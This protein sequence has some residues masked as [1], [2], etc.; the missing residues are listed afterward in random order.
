MSKKHHA[1]D[2]ESYE[3]NLYEKYRTTINHNFNQNFRCQKL[4]QVQVASGE[5]EERQ[6]IYVDLTGIITHVSDDLKKHK[7]THPELMNL[8]LNQKGLEKA[9]KPV[10]TLDPFG[11]NLIVV[12]CNKG[13][14][15]S[16]AV[17]EMVHE[18]LVRV[19]YER[20]EVAVAHLQQLDGWTG[21]HMCSTG[22][23]HC[24]IFHTEGFPTPPGRKPEEEEEEPLRR[25]NGNFSKAHGEVMAKFEEAMDDWKIVPRTEQEDD[26]FDESSFMQKLVDA[27]KDRCIAVVK[28]Y[29]THFAYAKKQKAKTVAVLSRQDVAELIVELQRKHDIE[30]KRI[31]KMLKQI[32]TEEEEPKKTQKRATS[33]PATCFKP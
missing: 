26:T 13:R 2:E 7:G 3:G 24:N 28:H 11:Y 5:I 8:I 16:P 10:S 30:P 4:D 19:W 22:C 32:D 20:E 18:Y 9:L 1:L 31:L 29:M 25:Y 6:V 17:A 33:T 21:N 12:I 15:W 23:K 14:I 27:G